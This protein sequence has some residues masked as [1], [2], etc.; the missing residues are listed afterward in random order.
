[1]LEK[2]KVAYTNY[3]LLHLT[4]WAGLLACAILLYWLSGGF[5]PWAWRFFF[6]ILP[7]IPLLWQVQGIAVLLPLIGLLCLA[8]TLLLL[9]GVIIVACI[10]MALYWWS[11]FCERRRFQRELQEAEQLVKQMVTEEM[12]QTGVA[13]G[14]MAEGLSEQGL[15]IPQT[16][17]PVWVPNNAMMPPEM[18][19]S[20]E[21]RARSESAVSPEL[22][23]I[24]H[25]ERVERQVQPASTAASVQP[26]SPPLA[27]GQLRLVPRPD[28]KHKWDD[29][30]IDEAGEFPEIEPTQQGEPPG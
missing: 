10:K 26:A 6:Q 12:R 4:G 8:L 1:M 24:Q 5:P 16:P 21:A 19:S 13:T 9:W 15:R 18:A 23:S 3:R 20:A 30:E 25:V 22:V 17:L 7:R 28:E 27:R 2:I 29:E 11:D 14:T